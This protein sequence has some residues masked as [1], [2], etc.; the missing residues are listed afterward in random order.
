MAHS[1]L[2][3]AWHLLTNGSL[4]DDPG[5]Q[6][7]ELRHDPAIEAK[8]LQRKIEAL[9]YQVTMTEIAALVTQQL[10]NTSVTKLWPRQAPRSARPSTVWGEGIT[11]QH[12]LCIRVARHCCVRCL[13]P[14]A[15]NK[16]LTLIGASPAS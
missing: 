1:I 9:G 5:A 12:A 3:V 14:G 6:Y 11:P 7:F 15:P 8:R 16:D 13:D 10:P 2:A 4:Y